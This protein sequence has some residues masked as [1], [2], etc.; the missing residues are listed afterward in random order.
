VKLPVDVRATWERVLAWYHGYSER[1]RRII[2]GV[3]IA[4]L[5]SAVYLLVLEPLLDYRAALAQDIADGQEELERSM[6]FIAAKGALNTEREDLRRRLAQA[7]ARLLPGGTGT[8]GAAALQERANA[9]ATEKGITIQ[10]TQ[11]MKEE[12][13]EPYHK[14][15]V[16]LTL[17]GEVKP[18][19]ELVSGLEYGQQL[20]IPFI[21][22]SR[23]G[24]VAGA[25]GPRNLSAT[26]EV[27]G[28]VQ[29]G[30]PAKGEASETEPAPVAE[31]Q[32]DAAAVDGSTTTVPSGNDLPTTSVPSG[33][34]VPEA[35]PATVATT[36]IPSTI[37]PAP[38]NLDHPQKPNPP[39]TG[40][41]GGHP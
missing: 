25:K 35:P 11:V 12:I 32:A 2:L 18:L 29:S 16:R 28:F 23:R 26:V 1:D 22:I 17:S 38:P 20:A 4:T 8:L 13:V 33:A 7:K 40:G 9:L 27:S 6:R 37:E 39:P 15:A 21:E 31:A 24:A 41:E 14:V 5:A 3:L 36:T 19:A 34:D 10:S 30:A